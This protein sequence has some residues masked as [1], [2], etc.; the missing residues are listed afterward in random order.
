MWTQPKP[1]KEYA[2]YMGDKWYG[3]GD[4]VEQAWHDVEIVVRP[5]S[6]R[7]WRELR[8]NAKAR[9]VDRST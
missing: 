5:A 7:F 1:T 9:K 4:S 3:E 8:Q 6:P 2:V